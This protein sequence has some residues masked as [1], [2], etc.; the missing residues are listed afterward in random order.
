MGE[1]TRQTS[2]LYA[3]PSFIGGMAHSLD[4]GC[5]LEVYNSNETPEEAD[6]KATQ[7]DWEAVGN[8]ILNSMIN[9]GEKEKE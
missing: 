5:T 8:D 9:Y 2:Y 7:N 1:I 3:V 4:M 6:T